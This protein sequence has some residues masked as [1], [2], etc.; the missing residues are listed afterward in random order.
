M[1]PKNPC[2][3]E[4][5]SELEKVKK[6]GGAVKS[7]P[8][9]VE[10]LLRCLLLL[11][12]VGRFAFTKSN[13]GPPL[14]GPGAGVLAVHVDAPW[15]AVVHPCTTSHSSQDLAYAARTPHVHPRR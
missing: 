6:K 10:L 4:K 5:L 8:L 7:S 2:E 3:K 15:T 12:L 9:V 1:T 11:L 14:R 13:A